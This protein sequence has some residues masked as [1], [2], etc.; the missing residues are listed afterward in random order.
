MF[1]LLSLFSEFDDKIYK[2]CSLSYKTVECMKYTGY[3]FIYI[4]TLKQRD[5]RKPKTAEMT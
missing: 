5:I 4:W 1:M 2:L 3:V